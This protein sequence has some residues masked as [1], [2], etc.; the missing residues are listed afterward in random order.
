[1][2]IFLDVL[3]DNA[4]LSQS[5]LLSVYGFYH[6]RHVASRDVDTFQLAVLIVNRVDVGLVIVFPILTGGVDGIAVFLQFG[7]AHD[8]CGARDIRMLVVDRVK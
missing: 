4:Q 3:V 2:D 8:G 7:N 5:I 6:F 1:M